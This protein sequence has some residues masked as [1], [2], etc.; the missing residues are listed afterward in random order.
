MYHLSHLIDTVTGKSICRIT[1]FFHARL[2]HDKFATIS[3]QTFVINVFMLLL[4]HCFSFEVNPCVAGGLIVCNVSCG[5]DFE[6][7]FDTLLPMLTPHAP[8]IVSTIWFE[9]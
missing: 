5:Y 7:L 1:A 9:A 2:V 4:E 6:I 8:I 3:P